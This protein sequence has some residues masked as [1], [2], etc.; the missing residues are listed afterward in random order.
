[1]L[2]SP[3]HG[4]KSRKCELS[5]T[6]CS[7][8]FRVARVPVQHWQSRMPGGAKAPGSRAFSWPRP[9]PAECCRFLLAAP[10]NVETEL[11]IGGATRRGVS[12]LSTQDRRGMRAIAE[13]CRQFFAQFPIPRR[14]PIRVSGDTLLIQG[15]RP[16][17]MSDLACWQQFKLSGGRFQAP[18]YVS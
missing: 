6:V 3:D 12:G 15:A 11:K 2:C 13:D 5:S 4:V 10:G 17:A 9:E 18:I 16:G 8:S 7:I 14:Y 1:M